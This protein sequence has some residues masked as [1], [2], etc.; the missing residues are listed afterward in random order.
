MLLD[1]DTLT[2]TDT[3]PV[4]PD[5]KPRTRPVVLCQGTLSRLDTVLP[6]VVMLGASGP[7][8]I[9][10]QQL[11]LVELVERREGVFGFEVAT[12]RTDWFQAEVF[13]ELPVSV[14]RR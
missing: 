2:C 11:S 4:R 10:I 8:A 14:D 13:V 9:G 1:A 12:S 3:S 6:A 5:P 7:S